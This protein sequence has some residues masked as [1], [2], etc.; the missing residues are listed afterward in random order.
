[1]EDTNTIQPSP[2]RWKPSVSFDVDATNTKSVDNS[3]HQSSLRPNENLSQ[4]HRAAIVPTL[5]PSRPSLS[6]DR[7]LRNSEESVRPSLKTNGDQRQHL[8][9]QSIE[10]E[11]LPDPD[12][13]E[14]RQLNVP[15]Q[16]STTAQQHHERDSREVLDPV[17]ENISIPKVLENNPQADPDMVTGINRLPMR[18]TKVEKDEWETLQHQAHSPVRKV[19]ER[20]RVDV[21]EPETIEPRASAKK[22]KYPKDS[23]RNLQTT[24]T[25]GKEFGLTDTRSQTNSSFPD[26]HSGQDADNKY[27]ELSSSSEED[28]LPGT[29]HV[30]RPSGLSTIS[31]T[32]RTS[33]ES[34]TPGVAGKDLPILSRIDSNS[35]ISRATTTS[36][37]RHVVLE[38]LKMIAR[39][40]F[41]SQDDLENM[42]GPTAL[43]T[44]FVIHGREYHQIPCTG[45]FSMRKGQ[46]SDLRSSG[47]IS[48]KD[49]AFLGSDEVSTLGQIL[50]VSD[51]YAKALI[52]LK[53]VRKEKFRFWWSS[54]RALIAI[55][56]NEQVILDESEVVQDDIYSVASSMSSSMRPKPLLSAHPKWKLKTEEYGQV[57]A[58]KGVWLPSSSS[59]RLITSRCSSIHTS[60]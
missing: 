2:S 27:T 4:G 37:K 38:A 11:M 39:R 8:I 18:H 34:V 45:H 22:L 41:L 23:E 48:W 30:T 14:I 29:Q 42:F 57:E 49:F 58:L 52:Q 25:S 24:K 15:R 26:P 1:V 9:S 5:R 33:S 20:S 6:S 40:D 46:M 60:R 53:W 56:Y 3:N 54:K 47:S 28:D 16:K 21:K 44:A 12:L 36:K 43:V 10:N 59:I 51:G 13:A 19:A 55:I 7:I 35:H 32:R 50:E 31:E 17:T